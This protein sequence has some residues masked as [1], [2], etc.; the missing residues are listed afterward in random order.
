MPNGVTTT[1]T[2]DQVDQVTAIAHTTAT[3]TVLA[4][5]TYE[6]DASGQPTTI[7]R[8]DGSYRELSYDASL[9]LT[10]EVFYDATSTA[11]ET[12]T[13]TYDAAGNR[14]AHSDSEGS[15][16]YSYGDGFQLESVVNG[17]ETDTYS[18][19]VDGR[20]DAIARDGEH[21]RAIEGR[22]VGLGPEDGVER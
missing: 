6:R 3:G 9:R 10:Q 5:F 15:H 17:T 2:Y 13:Y 7:T 12:I 21:G 20:L 18:H 11:Q 14:M 8:E 4:S 16:T 1:Y 19:D 22:D